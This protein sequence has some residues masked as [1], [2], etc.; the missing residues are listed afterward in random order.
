MLQLPSYL[1]IT[2][3][4]SEILNS[5]IEEWKP[6]HI[7]L[8][9]DENTKQHCLPKIGIPN[10]VVIE[11][12]SGEENKTLQTCEFV[13][14]ELTNNQFTRNSLL[15][16][17][18]GGVI[19][20]LGGYAASTFKRGIRFVNIPTT[21][22][23]QVDASIGGK[24]AI[25]F[26]NLKNQIG[27]FKNPDHVIIDSNFLQSLP[28]RELKSGFG[29]VIK[30][31]LIADTDQWNEMQ[32]KN[33]LDLNWK[34][35]IPNSIAI[36]NKIVSADPTDQ[37]IR[38]ILNFGHTIGHALESHF[39]HSENKLLHG[40]AIAL[41]M[42][43][44]SHLSYQKDWIKLEEWEQIKKFVQSI[45]SFPIA[46]PDLNL[47][48]PIMEQDKKNDSDG[49]NFSLLKEIGFCE[50]DVKVSYEMLEN[51]FTAYSKT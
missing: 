17:L 11:I 1:T 40:E 39:L 22:L 45:Y 35:V 44:E 12:S 14:N 37:G 31:T 26:G 6:D 10:H 24:L 50:Q 20:D 32:T 30:H 28:K 9:V 16:N 5:L 2:D 47:L 4:P 34:T 51:S 18:G 29:E 49:I 15:V 7:G 33:I 46:I 36:K 21:L 3:Q 8:L 27:L 41:G 38:K 23:A 48:Y 42:V 25:D 13:W 19:G 43:L